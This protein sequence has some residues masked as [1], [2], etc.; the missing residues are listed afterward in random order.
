MVAVGWLLLL[1][2]IAVALLGAAPAVGARTTAGTVTRSPS[3][4]LILYYIAG[5]LG[6]VVAILALI[7]LADD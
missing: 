6:I 2:G 4:A 7:R 5:A 3:T 1:L